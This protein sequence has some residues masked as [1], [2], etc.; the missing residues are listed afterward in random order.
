LHREAGFE[1]VLFALAAAFALLGFGP[2]SLGGS[3]GFEP[4]PRPDGALRLVTWNVGSGLDG[5]MRGLARD[6]AAAVAAALAELD[7]DVVA[8]QEVGDEVDTVL[9]ALG[10]GWKAARGS[11][12]TALLARG[13]RASAIDSFG[14]GRRGVLLELEA[15][16]ARLAL[17][18]VHAHAFDA[19]ARN[20]A[21]GMAIVDLFGRAA[22]V[23]VLLG[24]L[25]LDVDLDKRRDL[26]T[27]D[28][29]LDVET[30]NYAA[31]NLVDAAAGTGSTAEPDRRLDYVFVSTEAEVL[32]A[33]P[34]K[35]RRVGA[36]DHDPVVVDLRL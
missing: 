6:D 18:V 10:S 24:D 13:I 14:G 1:A 27:G 34:W 36:M 33:G 12:G 25:N 29:H 21:V 31:D 32:A 4:G 35:G 28:S 11:G 19:R 15:E 30:Y 3:V 23:H 22:D 20:A 8:L 5:R 2:P 7:A 9:R 26:F 17:A 16:E